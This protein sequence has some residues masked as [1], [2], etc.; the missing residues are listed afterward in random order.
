M[1]SSSNISIQKL[2]LNENTIGF[3]INLGCSGYVYGL[4]VISNLFNTLNTKRALLLVGDTVSKIIN[5]KDISNK[6]LFGDAGSATF[7]S[8][9]LKNKNN[10]FYFDIGSSRKGFDKLLFKNSGFRDNKFNPEFYMDGKEVFLFAISNVPKISESLI[11]YSKLSKN[12][13]KFFVFHQANLFL[14]NKIFD[15]LKIKK[16]KVLNSIVSY[17]NTNSASIPTTLS[18]NCKKLKNF[19]SHIMLSGFGAGFSYANLILKIDNI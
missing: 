10:S 18:H 15:S 19:K 1:P 9:S 6:L 2:N 16:N 17:G 7:I 5:K 13:T 8:K 11:K 12:E 4:W 3:D 14:L